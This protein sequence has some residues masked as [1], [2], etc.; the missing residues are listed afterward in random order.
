MNPLAPP[1]LP[2]LNWRSLQSEDMGAIRELVSTCLAI[3]GG[4]YFMSNENFVQERYLPAR[5]TTIGGF[6]SDGRLVA[7][8]AI[9][10]GADVDSAWVDIVGLVHPTYRGR[11]LGRFLMEWS[12]AE[13]RTLLAGSQ[14]TGEKS[15]YLKTESLTETAAR[16]YARYGFALKSAAEVMRIELNQSLPDAPF[17]EG[18]TFT[19]WTDEIANDFFEAYHASFRERPGF[20]GWSAEYWISQATEDADFSRDGSLLAYEGAQPVG[21]ITCFNDYIG[22]V[23]VRPEWRNKGLASALLVEAMRRAVIAG[24][25]Q[26]WLEVY[27]NNPNAIRVYTRLG[28]ANAGHRATFV[29]TPGQV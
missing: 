8:T 4:L 27:M 21:F 15:F 23:G 16:L 13:A 25:N 1:I 24:E 20:P 11:G 22:Q 2:E 12:T 17:P 7:C 5:G 19:S 3:D 28:F 18:I 29:L 14:T 26:M 6:D 9:N 10:L